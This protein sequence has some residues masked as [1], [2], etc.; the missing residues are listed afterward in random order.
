MSVVQE[1]M[2]EYT[3][4]RENGLD[5]KATLHALRPYIEP[6][7]D[8]H[9]ADLA[10]FLRQWERGELVVNQAPASSSQDTTRVNEP[11]SV[12]APKTSSVIR[13]VRPPSPIKPI[14]AKPR[15]G[16]NLLPVMRPGATW[17]ACPNCST[18]NKAS[19]IFCYACGHMMDSDSA[20]NTRHFADAELNSHPSEYFG[21]DSILILRMRETGTFYKLRP[22]Q[23]SHELVIGRSSINNAM[24]PDVDLAN[25]HAE[26]HGVSRLHVSIQYEMEN[27]TIQILDLGSANG[28]FINGQKLHPS[29]TRILRN[30]DELRLS[31]LVIR[32]EYE[33]PGAEVH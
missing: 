15:P 13:P 33:H 22:Q 4:M 20:M 14:E 23:Y 28:S 26:E 29:E 10:S 2:M 11:V 24:K 31:K 7:P 3:R 12:E 1:L 9:K 30:G 8:N 32:V 25:D 18:K 5:A 17:I 16:E 27:S 6:L 19:E 21:K